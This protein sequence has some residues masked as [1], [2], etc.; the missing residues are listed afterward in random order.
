M[1]YSKEL[2]SL[3]DLKFP[4]CDS[5][6]TGFLEIID[7]A[8]DETINTKLYAFFLDQAKNPAIA[9]VFIDALLEIVFEK[10]GKR[11]PLQKYACAL[12]V[13]TDKGNFIDL[14]ILDEENEAAIIVE[15]K[16]YHHLNN[17]LKDYWEHC[18]ASH[19]VGIVLSLFSISVPHS[20]FVNITHKE[21][22]SKVTKAGLP[23]SLPLNTRVYLN[24]FISTMRHI[25][26]STDMNEKVE[27]FFR[28]TKQIA[29]ADC[30]WKA[31]G[32]YFVNQ[33]RQ[34]AAEYNWKLH[35]NA[36]EHRSIWDE[37]NDCGAYYWIDF[38][39]MFTENHSVKV[40]LQLYG[41]DKARFSELFEKL[42][43]RYKLSVA[44]PNGD[45]KSA[46]I[47]LA[48]WSDKWEGDQSTSFSQF[49]SNGLKERLDPIMKE[50][51]RI[52]G[53]DATFQRTTRLHDQ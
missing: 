33:L 10:L 36:P 24:D 18:K 30:C 5:R 38:S 20:G 42:R 3:R 34:L 22:I 35:G 49:I 19:K 47:D 15:N 29:L 16:I 28:H 32:E 41:K 37:D 7:R 53:Y 21:W 6:P 23:D 2:E 12:E 25:T 46:Y 27:F 17:D 26:E 50:V 31:A 8:Y 11:I 9:Q 14:V 1:R 39:Q 45:K 13:E 40:Y 44:K 43:H 4:E 48:V 51:L 52:L